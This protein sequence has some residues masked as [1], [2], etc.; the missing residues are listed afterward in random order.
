VWGGLPGPLLKRSFAATFRYCMNA[1]RSASTSA[2]DTSRN[3]KK[4]CL[5]I[6]Y[7]FITKN[8]F[9]KSC[10]HTP[11]M[12]HCYLSWAPDNVS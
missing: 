6:S 9:R 2:A 8:T 5:K 4:K 1:V 12:G 11:Y 7:H 3:L 10:I